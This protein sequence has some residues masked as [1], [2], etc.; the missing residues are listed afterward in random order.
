[1]DVQHQLAKRPRSLSENSPGR[2]G[3]ISAQASDLKTPALLLLT[4]GDPEDS[5]QP[6][7]RRSS[8][9]QSGSIPPPH[10]PPSVEE[11]IPTV[12]VPICQLLADFRASLL[13][14]MQSIILNPCHATLRPGLDRGL[15]LHGS[16]RPDWTREDPATAVPPRGCAFVGPAV[17]SPE[18][19]VSWG[20]LPFGKASESDSGTACGSAL[21]R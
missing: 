14:R 11:G 1:M 9:F 8:R 2:E 18:R 19:H 13:R 3:K 10:W 5:D 20:P 15:D 21:R 12:D 6:T 4:N 7:R 17:S 16:Y